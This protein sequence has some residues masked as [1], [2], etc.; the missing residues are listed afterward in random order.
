LIVKLFGTGSNKH[1]ILI[2]CTVDIY[3]YICL[4]TDKNKCYLSATKS[5]D[6]KKSDKCRLVSEAKK[7]Y[8]VF[9]NENEDLYVRA[10]SL[11]VGDYLKE[12]LSYT[13]KNGHI[14][15]KFAGKYGLIHSLISLFESKTENDVYICFAIQGES[16]CSSQANAALNLKPDFAIMLGLAQSD[17][18][19]PLIVLKDGRIFSD[20][21]LINK[22]KSTNI[23]TSDYISDSKKPITKAEAVVC[24]ASVPT[25]TL[26]LPCR[27]LSEKNEE[28][29]IK[30]WEK[31]TRLLKSICNSIF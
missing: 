29:S 31:L 19:I 24:F 25:L 11:K 9:A 8:T 28:F 4:A 3:G 7:H 10:K 2:T 12:E 17:A 20:F 16:G 26:S 1:S 18:N 21:D 6:P 14:Y 22:A 23:K 30:A 13:E 27:S 5:L 15:G